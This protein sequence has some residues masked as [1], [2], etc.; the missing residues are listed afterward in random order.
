[1]KKQFFTLL[2][3]LLATFAALRAQSPLDT[4]AMRAIMVNQLFPQERVYLHFD[5]TAYYLGE[6]MWFKAYVTCGL[7]DE[8]KPQSRVLYV[9]LCA[10]EGYVVETK[11]YKLDE[12]GRC[13]G[14]FELRKEL[15]SG[16]YE[17]RA[18][19]RYML[20][21]GD[22][23]VF[24]RVF[25][26]YDKVNGDNY[27]F[28][29][30]LDRKRSFMREGK[31]VTEEL[32]P[33]DLK[34]YPE[35]GHI[36][37]G[38]EATVAYELLDEEGK[39]GTD[40][41][42]IFADKEV[43][44][45]SAPTHAGM[46]TFTFTPK[47]GIE[48]RAEVRKGK[49]K[50]KFD[51]PK[52]EPRGVVVNLSQ[53]ADNINVTIKN[54]IDFSTPLGIAVLNRGFLIDYQSFDSNDKEKSFTFATDSLPEGVNR[55]VIFA[56]SNI[57][58]A[59][60]QFFVRHKNI[61]PGDRQTIKL[62]A[63]VNGLAPS[64]ILLQ[65]HE[66]ITLTVE[67]EDGKPID[68]DAEFSVSVSDAATRQTMSYTHN[69]YTHM[70]LGSELKGYIPDAA[71]YFADDSDATRKNLDLLM[72]T[73][74]WTSYD[75]SKLTTKHV[76]LAQPIERGIL[77][78]GE[79]LKIEP[80]KKFGE[81]NTGAVVPQKQRWMTLDVSYDNKIA[82]TH[83]AKTNNNG[84]FRG[85]TKDFFGKRIVAITPFY[86]DQQQSD[87]IFKVRMDKYFSPKF[88]IYSY[89]QR[90][91]GSSIKSINSDTAT[92]KLS[93]YEYLLS[94]VDI[95][96]NA[97]KEHLGRPPRSE[98]RFNFLDEWEYAIDNTYIIKIKKKESKEQTDFQQ[99]IESLKNAGT[100]TIANSQPTKEPEIWDIALTQNTINAANVLRSAFWRYNFNWAYWVQLIVVDGFYNP[101]SIVRPDN[102][103][104]KGDNEAKMMHFKEFVI[105]SDKG[106]REQFHNYA[107]LWARKASIM[108]NKGPFWVGFLT[109]YYIFP[110]EYYIN[111]FE[112]RKIDG[113][114][115]MSRF[116]DHMR[117]TAR[118]DKNIGWTGHFN[119]LHPNY[120]ACFIPYNEKDKRTSII[121]QLALPLTKRYTTLQGY[122]RSK[123][124]YSPDY[125]SKKP[126]GRS[127]CRRTILWQPQLTA[128]SL[129]K[130]VT[131]YNNSSAKHLIVDIEGAGSKK[132]YSSSPTT[133]TRETASEADAQPQY[134]NIW[135]K[136]STSL[137]GS[138]ELL[139]RCYKETVN[140]VK[141]FNEQRFDEAVE[142]FKA[143]A[144][145]AYPGAMAYLG[146][147]YINEKGVEENRE[148]GY[149]YLK[150]AA[151]QGDKNAWYFMGEYHA[152]STGEE[153]DYPAAFD[154]YL[155][156]AEGGHKQAQ[157][158]LAILYE[159]GKGVA[160]NDSAAA[161]W[162]Q[163]A[164]EKE[165]PT[166]LYRMGIKREKL[167]SINN[168]K[169]KELKKS[170]AFKYLLRAAEKGVPEA[171]VKVA[172]HY[173]KGIYV[174]KSK[175]KAFV[176]YERAAAN[177]NLQAQEIVAECYEKGRGTEKNDDAAYE[178]Y[179][180]AAEQGSKLG[181]TK[182]KEFE[183]FNFYK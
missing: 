110:Y 91:A 126:E 90:N 20:N 162:Y 87:S 161:K 138:P 59:E 36:V 23:A 106:T 154:C 167:D 132:F 102:E 99:V 169:G 61:L 70:L 53:T 172:E 31:W 131:F 166:A 107:N 9:E 63:K 3:L 178:W 120:V 28:K 129:K 86:N 145:H 19:T 114:P 46:G 89:W 39:A 40:S 130:S 117:G 47:S 179:K 174:K 105:R 32:P 173:T 25:P 42:F 137:Q 6:T 151:E 79:I 134:I 153:A 83:L 54:N 128:D 34:F 37:E 7:S 108:A 48:Y 182:A 152:K 111:E 112:D 147:C 81:L 41:I 92:I 35:G 15:L 133:V 29:N 1:M 176:W 16:Y 11:K 100:A 66:K 121:P 26:V 44:L 94:G 67:R 139:A 50:H 73:R 148:L 113:F 22:E 80:S 65:P 57:P 98:I 43:L 177:G 4:L 96:D 13:N 10:P 142:K 33:A 97:V 141:L 155:R 124:F 5:N 156:A 71:Q 21:W 17:V 125:S 76:S 69:M 88:N 181:K 62:T 51:L 164:A 68:K 56:N 119:P 2:F 168:L 12:N 72:L 127:D 52:I 45:K 27:D 171:V 109:R 78:K 95:N 144:L 77:L 118:A 55:V 104:I 170:P 93:E 58:L 18:Y 140:G 115:G 149:R 122:N 14:E 150:M 82:T 183:L 75:W 165:E 24:S 103:Y 146:Y 38:I 60:R 160:K 180:R 175:K 8:E 101:D 74:G 123:S 143:S 85:I 49:K 30:M 158:E 64:E 135:K 157:T 116:Y 136:L 163:L 159:E 84:M